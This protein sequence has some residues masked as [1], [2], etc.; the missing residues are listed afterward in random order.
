MR[1]K[2]LLEL[3]LP[4]S[5]WKKERREG[6]LIKVVGTPFTSSAK[7]KAESPRAAAAARLAESVT[8]Q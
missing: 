6:G 4:G 7:S 1:H 2:H 3:I 8:G 5:R